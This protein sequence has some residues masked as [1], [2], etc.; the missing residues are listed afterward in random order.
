[1]ITACEP[2]LYTYTSPNIH[3]VK[4]LPK[5]YRQ[6]RNGIDHNCS[7][8]LSAQSLAS[9]QSLAHL[10][11]QLAASYTQLAV[12]GNLESVFPPPCNLIEFWLPASKQGHA[13]WKYFSTH[14]RVCLTTHFHAMLTLRMSAAIPP[15]PHC[16]FTACIGTTFS[17]LYVNTIT[18]R[19]TH[20]ISLTR[21]LQSISKNLES[22]TCLLIKPVLLTK[23]ENFKIGNSNLYFITA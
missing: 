22:V 14:D 2:V 7:L 11:P 20:G 17:F 19:N 16:T 13:F 23:H 10:C 15:F 1:V 21:I 8:N 6:Q 12:G 18:L 5:T 3:C 4:H 9:T